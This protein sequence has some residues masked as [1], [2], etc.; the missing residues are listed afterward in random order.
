MKNSNLKKISGTIISVIVI[1]AVMMGLASCKDGGGRFGSSPTEIETFDVIRGDIIQTV[2]TTG[3][4]EGRASN[5]YSL[6]SSGMVLQALKKGDTFFEG[7]IL[8]KIDNSRNELLVDQAE[9]NL[10]IAKISLEI[11][12]LSL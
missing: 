5:N 9:E 12:K 11:T 8:I 7:D 10:N 6:Q 1:M 4:V 2:T 3:Y